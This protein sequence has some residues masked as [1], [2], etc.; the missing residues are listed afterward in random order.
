M[1]S[2]FSLSSH[3]LLASSSDV[4]LCFKRFSCGLNLCWI[5]HYFKSNLNFVSFIKRN[6]Y[7]SLAVCK[8]AATTV[9][10]GI[11]QTAV[12]KKC[13]VNQLLLDTIK[14]R[15]D[16]TLIPTW[17]E[18]PAT[19]SAGQWRRQS[20]RSLSC[21]NPHCSG[22]C[23]FWRILRI[24]IDLVHKMSGNSGS[25]FMAVVIAFTIVKSMIL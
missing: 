22:R 3:N 17:F 12:L 14:L 23:R 8:V 21:S 16:V 5:S 11:V 7:P 25:G 9:R 24:G 4:R 18:R 6:Y 15:L 1:P 13:F 10:D 20:S 2:S 19:K